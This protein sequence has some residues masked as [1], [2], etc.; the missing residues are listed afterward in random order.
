MRRSAVTS[1][2]KANAA[3]HFALLLVRERGHVTDA[4]LAAVKVAGFGDGA[5]VE[6]VL[7]VALT[8]LTNCVGVVAGTEI[9]FPRVT[10]RQAARSRPAGGGRGPPVCAAPPPARDHAGA[11]MSRTS[12]LSSDAAFTE[13]VKAIQFRLGSRADYSRLERDGGFA[14]EIGEDLSAFIARQRSIFLATRRVPSR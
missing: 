11:A 1:D 12:S 10:A 7:H 9:D 3:V 13:Q 6:I 5:V 8:T 14:T 2:P 4:D